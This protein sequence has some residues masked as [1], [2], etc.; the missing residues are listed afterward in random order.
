MPAL[1]SVRD[2]FTQDRLGGRYLGVLVLVGLTTTIYLGHFFWERLSILLNLF[3]PAILF[4]GTQ[5]WYALAVTTAA[6]ASC[7]LVSW[8][9]GYALACIAGTWALSRIRVLSAAGNLIF[10]VM[11]L[12]YIVPIVLTI[13]LIR[14]EVYWVGS[15]FDAPTTMRTAIPLGISVF[16]LSGYQIFE[17]CFRAIVS[18]DSR[19]RELVKALFIPGRQANWSS[20]SR[21]ILYSANR[22]VDFNRSFRLC[23]RA[24]Y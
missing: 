19:A 24:S 12:F 14:A 2:L 22:L 9:R 15:A 13:T 23:E 6:A 16:I 8:G 11:E 4:L 21:E 17:C 18:P 5:D 10:N 7:F 20:N 1:R 3:P